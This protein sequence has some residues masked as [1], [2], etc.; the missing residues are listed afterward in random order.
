MSPGRACGRG[1]CPGH[2][3]ADGY[4]DVCGLRAEEAPDSR[5]P[6][7]GRPPPPR[8]LGGRSAGTLVTGSARARGSRRTTS[9]ATRTTSRRTAIGAGLVDV[10]PA[11][12]VDPVSVVL[13]NP[14]VAEHKRF[15]SGCG[16]PVGR[17]RR[18]VPGRLSG[19]CASCGHRFDLVPK[20][21]RGDRVGGQ[22]EIVGCLAHGGLGWIYL[23]QDEAVND[24]WVVLKGLLDSGDEAAM[25]VAVAERRFL[26]E[27]QHPGVVGIFN[28]VTHDGAGYIVEEY[29]GGRSLKQIL[30]ARRQ[31]NG[32]EPDPLPVDQAIAYIL[33]I[34]PAFG[35]L[36]G[37][38]LV[39][40]DFKPDNLVQVG[41]HLKLIDL[42]AVR[43]IDDPAGDVYGTVGYQAPEIVEMGP[44]IASDIY[45]I[46]RTLAVLTLYFPGYNG[47]HQHTLPDPADHAVLTR[48]DS[49]H[50]F[51]LKA[52][53][54]HP[55]DRFQSV[56]E[57]GDQLVGVL[58]EVVAITTGEPQPAPSTVF[59]PPPD[60][61]ATIPP[62]GLN[63]A[64]PAATFLANIHGDDPAAVVAQI[65]YARRTDQVP[66]TV[67][68]RLRLARAH[69]ELAQQQ[70]ADAGAEAARAGAVLDAIDAADPWEWRAAWLRGQLELGR[71]D[72]GAAAAAFE[73]CRTEVPGELAPTLAAAVAAE[74][75]GHGGAAAVLYDLVSSVD[76]SYVA[77]V[78]GLARCRVAAGDVPGALDAYNRIPRSHRAYAQSQ[79]D[80]VRTL[81]AAGRYDEASARLATLDVD[82]RLRV[83]ITIELV[84]RAF[85]DARSGPPP[86]RSFN[87]RPLTE[88]TARGE[89]ER[90]LR[91]LAELTPDDQ[92]RY[93]LVDQAN[94]VRP[95]TVL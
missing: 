22:Y 88:R 63:A 87:G 24:R 78:A 2:M 75:A 40:C 35:H 15:C 89:L 69:I 54:Q 72:F 83:E 47:T 7:P 37:R 44:S 65:G 86:G 13:A 12:P 56:E 29:V 33:A 53:A 20:L 93:A 80:A 42:G 27:V 3:D 39:Y 77:A 31:A 38:R 23:A 32:G 55:D 1:R 92:Q 9:A 16:V 74:R 71:G 50:R 17:S 90:S 61:G 43:R 76:P 30:Q 19:F 51:L 68:V 4:C 82:E 57:L 41:D 25:A 26:A 11:P 8:P 81:F 70:G 6:P 5:P 34:L 52:T 18:G 62:L 49:F 36:H 85:D 94:T 64:D 95:V 28:F 67:E 10:P 45:T 79:L 21:A 66:E 73:R 59:G 14:E 84:T 46:G 48:F 91:R 60:D 58:R